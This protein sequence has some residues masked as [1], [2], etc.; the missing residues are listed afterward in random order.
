MES[1]FRGIG[2]VVKQKEKPH[3][4]SRCSVIRDSAGRPIL[5]NSAAHGVRLDPPSVAYNPAI[6]G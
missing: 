1:A 4:S 6:S 5:S 3:L 2:F